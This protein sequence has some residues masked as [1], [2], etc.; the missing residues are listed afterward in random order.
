MTWYGEMMIND[1]RLS[2]LI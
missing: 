1:P 2:N